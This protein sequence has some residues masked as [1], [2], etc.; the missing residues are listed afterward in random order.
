MEIRFREDVISCLEPVLRQ[1][2]EIE[3][4]QEL[5][6]PD[7]MPDAGRVI[8]GWA[9]PVIRSKEWRSDSVCA[10]GGL[11]VWALY[12]PEDGSEPRWTDCWVPFQ[13]KWDIPAR[14]AD[15]VLRLLCSPSPVDARLISARKMMFRCPVRM[16]AEAYV[17][18]KFTVY[19]GQDLPEDV[20][21]L[22]ENYPLVLLREAGEQQIQLDEEL[23]LNA[24]EPAV[25]KIVSCM[26]GPQITEQKI[27][28]DK[29]VFRGSLTLNLVYE[30]EDQHLH[31]T[32]V[33]VPFSQIGKLDT[34]YGPDARGDVLVSLTSHDLELTEDGLLKLKC[35]LVGQ[36]VVEER[37]MIPI[38][39]DAYS[40]A[41]P[42]ELAMEKC[43]IPVILDRRREEIRL[44]DK[45]S[46]PCE[47]VIQSTLYTGGLQRGDSRED[48][49]LFG[50][51]QVLYYDDTGSVK[52]SN[53]RWKET[54]PFSA[55]HGCEISCTP[56]GTERIRAAAD[57]GQISVSCDLPVNLTA[58]C[59]QEF[60]MVTGL[61][62]TQ[63]TQERPRRPSLILRRKGSQTLWNIAK[64]CG[65]TVEDILQAN[66][67][68][69]DT[70]SSGFLLIPVR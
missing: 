53:L 24:G 49:A 50:S 45:L 59:R 7:A 42:A 29:I 68:E 37:Q 44:E 33:S 11:T 40:F 2:Q 48:P 65:T 26:L 1:E 63:E 39:K 70:D 9:Q 56:P 43:A 64:S 5:R 15:G 34:S 22:T 61:T 21:V 54:I 17:P 27:T 25:G 51:V 28:G 31:G 30:G 3:V 67:L 47:K 13:M 41:R 14:D 58:V 20:Q 19:S 16:L 36:F 66:G 35:G 62:L 32:S 8:C 18:G 46:Q 69:E 12:A 23:N 52:S 4:T 38:T 55:H 60:S 6:L 57:G 10:S